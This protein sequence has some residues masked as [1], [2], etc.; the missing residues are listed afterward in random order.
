MTKLTILKRF[1]FFNCNNNKRLE[2][3]R[4]INIKMIAKRAA[5]KRLM[6]IL[7]SKIEIWNAKGRR[8][9]LMNKKFKYEIKAISN[10]EPKTGVKDFR[11]ATNRVE[12]I[13]SLTET[14]G[15]KK[16]LDKTLG[17]K[18][19]GITREGSMT[20]NQDTDRLGR[21]SLFVFDNG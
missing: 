4:Y 10:V 14:D 6:Q 17:K 3:L 9:K 8:I 16:S 1:G 21:R 18:Q 7:K 5:M 13:G 11:S 19:S 15:V 2:K 12:E 20:A